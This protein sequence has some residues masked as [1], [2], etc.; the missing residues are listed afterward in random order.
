MTLTKIRLSSLRTRGLCI[1]LLLDLVALALVYFTPKIGELIHLPFYMI[2][3]MRLMVVL[4]IAHSSR[5]NSY[6]LAFSLSLFSWVISGHPEFFK[7]LVMT[8]EM[9]AN[10]FLFYYFFRKIDSA[11]LPMI[12]SI[13]ISKVLCYAMYLVFF[14]MMFLREEADPSFLV[15]Q[16]I[17]TLVFSSYVFLIL[18]KKSQ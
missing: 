6:L 16:V 9:T 8:V 14:S 17:T 15:A 11:F 13:V 3:P 18:R 1:A 5:V 7:M 12:I 4:S 10:V 2:E